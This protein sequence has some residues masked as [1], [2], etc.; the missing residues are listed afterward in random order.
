MQSSEKVLAE[1]VVS[2][3]RKII[4]MLGEKNFQTKCKNGS[5]IGVN[6]FSQ[7][8]NL[9]MFVNEALEGE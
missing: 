2:L 6:V 9:Y 4:A 3:G 7:K 5:N 1:T 8:G